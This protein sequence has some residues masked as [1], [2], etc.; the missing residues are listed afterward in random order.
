M[1]NP[2]ALIYCRVSSQQQV[3]EGTGLSSQE[4]RCKEY[5]R[6]KKY[7][8]EKIFA[9]EG[10]SGGLFDRPKMNELIE[11]CYYYYC[12][13]FV[14]VFDDLKRFA[15]DIE[16][17]IRLRREFDTRGVK[18]ESPN[19]NFENTEEGRFVEGIIALTAQLERGQNR[20]QVIQKQK[21]R[22]EQGYW[23]FCNP[24]GL[25]YIKSNEHGKL[26]IPDENLAPIYKD[27]IEQFANGFIKTQTDVKDYITHRYKLAGIKKKTSNHGVRNI[28]EE[29][30][31]TGYIEYKP[32]DVSLRKGHHEGFI[33]LETYQEVQDRLNGRGRSKP[34]NY[35]LE[36]F[37]LR[38]LILC[39][40][41]KLALTASWNKGRSKL[42]GNYTCKSKDCIFR[43]KSIG[44][45]ILHQDFENLLESATLKGQ[46]TPLVEAIFLDVWNKKVS[47][48][49]IIQKEQEKKI[50]DNKIS[51]KKYFELI[52]NANLT[53]IPLYEE[54]ITKLQNE[55]MKLESHENEPLRYTQE[56]FGT[57]LKKVIN[58]L[59]NPIDVWRNESTQVKRNLVNFYFDKPLTY[60]K[61]I[62][63]GTAEYRDQI[64]LI[65]SI[66]SG[67]SHL[68][69]MGGIEPPCFEPVN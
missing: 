19:F 55:N 67:N 59:E 51:I 5:C 6:T 50:E 45:D 62:G 65:R 4:Q 40:E 7:E 36:D 35:Y 63:F 46:F 30:L 26:L 58:T 37:P 61:N 3:V 1:S 57:A 12:V 24:P 32:W 11:S 54:E 41:C 49:G 34:W 42:Y 68:V 28:L 39:D 66:S 23:P 8:V 47:T 31:Y 25:K 44:K 20:R 69:E 13:D 16:V 9:D 56:Q 14:V 48:Y 17:H 29:I 18:L 52:K 43:W 22:L 2:K 10:I 21:A 60:R 38:G 15:R 53:M 33:S 27:V 64:T